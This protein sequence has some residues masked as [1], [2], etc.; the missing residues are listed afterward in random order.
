MID[1]FSELKTVGLTALFNPTFLILLIVLF[2]LGKLVGW[3]TRN[4]NVWKFL[5]VAYFGI[6]LFRPLQD[7]G[8][9]IG[10]VFILGVASMY[11]DLFRGIFGWA[12]GFGDVVSAFRSRSAYEDIRRLEREIE[13][14]KSQLRNSQAGPS[15]AGGSAQQ[16]SWRAQAQARKAKPSSS[17]SGRGDGGQSGSTRGSQFSQ[18]A[19][20]GPLQETLHTSRDHVV[21]MVQAA[22]GKSREHTLRP[23]QNQVET[24]RHGQ[25]VHSRA[26]KAKARRSLK[27]IS[28]QREASNKA[29]RKTSRDPLVQAPMQCHQ[30]CATNTSRRSS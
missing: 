30:L 1:F 20:A 24:V 8:L 25:Q 22:S 23:A 5:T 29:P 17:N 6:F 14:L 3:M 2:F 7:A 9:I 26:L 21:L 28:N 11:M 13:A 15:A 18:N 27:A 12:G 4:I 10:G 16:A 19:K